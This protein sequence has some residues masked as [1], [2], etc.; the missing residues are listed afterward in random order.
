[1]LYEK[2]TDVLSWSSSSS[3]LKSKSSERRL[4]TVISRDLVCSKIPME[5]VCDVELLRERVRARRIQH[6]EQSFDL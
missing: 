6:D 1:M 4:V 2:E 5:Y 3:S